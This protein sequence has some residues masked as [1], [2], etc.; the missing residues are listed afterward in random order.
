MVKKESL[1]NIN[2]TSSNISNKYTVGGLFGGIGGIEL[3]FQKAGF[4]IL[5]ANEIDK[6]AAIT[7]RAN[8][9]HKLF[10]KDLKDLETSEVDK[11]DILTGGFP[12]QAFSIAGYRKGFKDDRGNMFFEILRFIDDL[13]PKII[14]L[15]NVKN[16]QTHDNGNTFNVI[17]SELENRG[18]LLKY[19]V[20][21]SSEYGNIPQNRERIYIV[22]FLNKIHYERFEFPKPIKLTKKIKDFIDTETEENFYYTHSKYYNQL[23]AEMINKNTIYQWRRVYVRENKNNLCPTLTA[24][25]GT[26]GHNVPLIIDNKDIR[27]LTPRECARF[28]GYDETFILPNIANSHLYKQIGNS[29]T[30]RVIEL[31]ANNIKKAII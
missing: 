25:M 1:M 9:K 10:L 13:K 19:K 6:N 23:K 17:K 11:I 22:G 15:E 5:W 3:G 16:L 14:F 28:Q 27:K 30:V 12:C 8:H 26:G 31:I 2:Q 20:L 29:V 4:N 7:Y 21:N 24:N 18:Y